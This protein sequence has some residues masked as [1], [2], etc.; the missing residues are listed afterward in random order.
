MD[1][2]G[3]GDNDLP[4]YGSELAHP[5]P[6]AARLNSQARQTSA[7][8][9]W[10][11]IARCSTHCREHKPGKK[12]SPRF[13]HDQRRVQ[14]TNSGWKLEPDGKR[15]TFTDGHGIGTMRFIGK[16]GRSAPFALS[17]IKRVRLVKRADGSACPFAVQADR[18]LAPDPTSTQVGSDV[19]LKAF[20]TESDGAT[21]ANPRYLGKAEA[22]LKRLQRR[23]SRKQKRSKNRKKASKRLAKGSLKGSRRRTDVARKAARALVQSRDLVAY[24]DVKISHRIKNR[25]LAKRISDAR[26]GLFLAWVRSSGGLPGIP[27][28]AVPPKFT[29]QDGSGCG[30]RVKKSLSMRTP[31]CPHC[32]LVLDRDWNAALNSLAA[33]RVMVAALHRTAGQAGTGAASAAGNASGQTTTTRVARKGTRHSGWLKAES[34]G[35]IRESVNLSPLVSVPLLS[36]TAAL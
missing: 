30:Y 24:E 26:W 2:R 28:V 10:L 34:P 12:G 1:G 35:F 15:I 25:Q 13:Q 3:V 19:G 4:V 22:T 5:S 33:A 7:D 23:V 21:G 27:V 32:G 17:P 6:C 9:A 14:D 36:T 11:S 20:S 8:R 29:T 16:K 18:P 31:I